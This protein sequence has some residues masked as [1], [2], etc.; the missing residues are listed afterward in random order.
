MPAVKAA[1]ERATRDWIRRF[2]VQER[3]C[4]FAAASKVHVQV[5]KIGGAAHLDPLQHASHAE[6]AFAA[7][8]RAESWV[9]ALLTV[10]V[11]RAPS[12]NLFIVWPDGL[13]RLETFEMFTAALA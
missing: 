3:L 7:L 12:S 2:V 13:G 6:L 11:A 10:E 5:D 1:V 4:P 9:D 8:S